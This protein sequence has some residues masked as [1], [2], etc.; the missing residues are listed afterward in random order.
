MAPS[1]SCIGNEVRHVV[2]PEPHADYLEDRNTE[3]LPIEV[4]FISVSGMYLN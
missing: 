3:G 2:I 4:V 1:D